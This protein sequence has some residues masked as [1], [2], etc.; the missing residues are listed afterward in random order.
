LRKFRS[1]LFLTLLFLHNSVLGADPEI[2]TVTVLH[3]NDV[4]GHL[5]PMKRADGE[6]RGGIAALAA[7]VDKIKKENEGKAGTTL[8]L[9]AGDV[10]TGVPDSDY[11]FAEPAFKTMNLIPFD[12]MVLGNHEFDNGV[13]KL[14]LQKSW[15]TFPFLSANILN[16]DSTPVVSPYVILE[17]KGLRIGILGLTTDTLKSLTVAKDTQHLKVLNPIKVAKSTLEKMKG[18]GANF[19]IALTH[20][21]ASVTGSQH[22]KSIKNDDLKLAQAKLGIPLIIGG[23]SHALLR[24]GLRVDDT[25]IAQAGDKGEYLG[26]VDLE[27]NLKDR[28]VLSSKAS[29]I[30]INP[31]E[32]EKDEVKKVLL[33]F[34]QQTEKIFNGVVGR[35]AVP[36]DGEREHVNHQETN[37]GNLV[38]DVVRIS[39]GAD[40]AV[41]NGGGI[42]GSIPEGPIQLRD[43][44]RVLP[45]RN[46]IVKAVFT[47]RAV[48][49]LLESSITH[50]NQPAASFLHVSGMRYTIKKGRLAKVY[51]QNKELT[52]Q[53]T[54]TLATTNFVMS[55]GD[56]LE[57]KV[58]ASKIE[59]TGILM[60]DEFVKHLRQFR[61]VSPTLEGR[62]KIID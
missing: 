5:W 53:Q 41:Y 47:G 56:N 58:Q 49:K 34:E 62:I 43:V 16:P 29:V 7:L 60:A 24:D 1:F 10:N 9:S 52:P 38:S 37:L 35:A 21:G 44:Q 54:L 15:A 2:F 57:I 48:R 20:L 18:E 55:G 45:F 33:P 19:I 13:E 23:H 22:S 3:T 6:V 28:K 31:S 27:W 8:L 14:L 17:R 51:F 42:R 30:R 36:L 40:V 46:T 4:H 59:D 50:Q 11:F 61:S 12:A 25:L 26:R 32:G 39:A